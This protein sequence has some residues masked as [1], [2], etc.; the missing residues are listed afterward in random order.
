MRQRRIT[1]R[2]WLRC[3]APSPKFRLTAKLH[4]FPKRQAVQKVGERGKILI[5][6]GL[7]NPDL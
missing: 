6:S 5:E 1:E 7:V 4:I 2:I 3:Y